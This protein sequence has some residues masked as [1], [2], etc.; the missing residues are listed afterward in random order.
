MTRKDMGVRQTGAASDRDASASIL[1]VDMDAFFVA[2]EL[3]E[4][5]DLIGKPVIVGGTR[6]RGVVSSAS[7]EARARGVRSAMPMHQAIARCPEAVVLPGSMHKYR[8]ASQQVMEIFR[9]FTPLVEPLSIDEAFLDVSGA[10]LLFGTPGE[11]AA[12]LRERVKAQTG[13]TCSV[14][15]ASTKFVAK[16]ASGKCKPNGMLVIPHEETIPFLHHLPVGALWGVGEKSEAK[17]RGIGIH[18]VFDLA[19]T[20]V[21]VLERAVGKAGAAKLSALAWGR[22]ERGVEE[23]HREKSISHEQTFFEDVADFVFLEREVRAQADAVA[24]RLRRAGLQ[25]RQVGIKLRW[26]DFST[27]TRSHT[28]AEPSDVGHSLYLEAR[29]M[30]RAALVPP[31]PVRLIG[32]R[33]ER[34]V[35]AGT[36]GQL[37]LFGA[38]E[39]DDWE[40]AE[41]AVDQAVARFG[42]FALRPASLLGRGERSDGTVGL[43]ERANRTRD[44]AQD[45]H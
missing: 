13:L 7:Y 39:D 34:L 22:D 23:A 38:E 25:A 21:P 8:E 29:E 41:R 3:L 44:E 6:E 19:H 17:L 36:S 33:A 43:S 37:S 14:G 2:V 32:V 15:A 26:S 31:R 27:I 16:L 24:T 40:A 18:T 4:R 5:P 12:R 1:H 30:L 20:P 9:E 45:Q 28:L 10:S 35:E 42:K 11:I